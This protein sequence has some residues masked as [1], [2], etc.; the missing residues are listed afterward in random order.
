ML[1][2]NYLVSLLQEDFLAGLSFRK[3]EKN[4]ELQHSKNLSNKLNLEQH[5]LLEKVI[6]LNSLA[7]RLESQTKYNE[8][9]TKAQAALESLEV[10]KQNLSPVSSLI[11]IE[12]QVLANTGKITRILGNY[13]SAEQY[14]LKA[15]NLAQSQ[16]IEQ[17]SIL[18]SM[19][20][21][22]AVVYKYWGK[23][24][25][26]EQIYQT[27][28]NTLIKQY[29]E[30]SHF[31]ATIYHNYAGLEHSRFNY[32][33]AE[34]LARKSYEI[35]QNV[36]GKE[37]PDTIAD[38][39]ALGS[40]L[41]GLGKWDEAV[42]LF[43]KAIT[44]FD[45]PSNYQPYE[46]AVNLNNLA[47]SLQ[48]KGEFLPAEKAYRRA[49]SIKKTVFGDEHPDIAVT[50]NNL[51]ILLKEQEQRPEAKSILKEALRI[52]EKTVGS[53]HPQT[54]LCKKNISSLS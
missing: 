22:L 1:L 29:G 37:H 31:V 3:S 44:F 45:N 10:A 16:R 11:D 46:V 18:L 48:A 5:S 15:I 23:F 33:K 34:P 49:L 53:Q 50:L 30:Q 35:R 54:I 19:L 9:L 24:D 43:E 7:N 20:N 12:I 36:C 8:A 6:Q 13:S 17:H 27:L 21:D 2:L 14:Y 25:A 52:F 47:A 32:E 51:A 28:L 39:A 40:I 41:H 42:K 38:G 4:V 26:G